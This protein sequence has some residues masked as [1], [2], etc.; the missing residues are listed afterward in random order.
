MKRSL[1]R[2]IL[3]PLL[4]IVFAVS[5]SASAILASDMA[6][7]MAMAAAVGAAG[8][9]KCQGCNDG[10]PD[11]KAAGCTMAFCTMHVVACLAQPLAVIGIDCLDRP[12][13]AQRLLVGWMHAPDPYPPRPLT[14]G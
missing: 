13:L 7:R 5:M 11:T 4:G 2:R 6:A 12:V 1:L 3:T 14:L 10:I 8:D 9:G